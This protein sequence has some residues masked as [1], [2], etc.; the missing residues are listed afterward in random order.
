VVPVA[1][2]LF[3]LELERRDIHVSREG[4]DTLLVG[5]PAR[6]TNADRALIRQYKPHLLLLVDFDGEA[7]RLRKGCAWV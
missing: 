7:D 2:Y 1:P 6:L 4:A 3:L 5:P